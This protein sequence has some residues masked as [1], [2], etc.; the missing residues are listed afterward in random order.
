MNPC[1]IPKASSSTLIIGAR[2]LVVQEA[3]DTIRWSSGSNSCS[4]TPITKVAS[5]PLPGAETTTRDAPAFRWAAAWSRLRK[6][7][8]DSITTSTPSSP[9]GKA[10]GSASLRTRTGDPSMDISP[11]PTLTGLGSRPKTESRASSLAIAAG[12]PKSLTATTVIPTSRP[13]RRATRRGL[14]DRTH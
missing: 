12:D 10:D 2:Q 6:W 13:A 11:F 1:S 3:F 5:S 8:V 4:L 9:Q 7:P 14:F